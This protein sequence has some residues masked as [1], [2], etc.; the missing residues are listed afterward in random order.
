MSVVEAVALLAL[1]RML[2]AFE[3]PPLRVIPV[4]NSA[5]TAAVTA[6]LRRAPH[7]TLYRFPRPKSRSAV[8]AAV[9]N[10]LAGINDHEQL[11][12]T[13]GRAHGAGARF[14][15]FWIGHG[16][17]SQVGLSPLALQTIDRQLRVDGAEIL[18]VHNHPE[19]DLKTLLRLLVGW[20]PLP[21]GQDR[22]TAFAHNMRT[23]RVL[24]ESGSWACF[25]WYLVD[26]GEIA[27]FYLPSIEKI[28]HVLRQLGR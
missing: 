25:K 18:V 28:V 12:V 16:G 20:R 5:N 9:R 3:P 13:F 10:Y 11:V 24:A 4:R 26:E 1:Q 2:A 22:D 27:E 15:G 7:D 14:E 6:A 19:H 23:W 17:R 21:S 8:L